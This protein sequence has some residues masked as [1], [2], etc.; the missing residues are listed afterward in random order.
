MYLAQVE[1]RLNVTLEHLLERARSW[2][3]AGR[4]VALAT[5]VVTWGS[6]PRPVGSHLAVDEAG[7]FVGSVSGGCIEGAVIHEA[8]AV[9]NDGTPRLLDFGVTNEQAWEVGLACGG[10]VQ[11]YIERVENVRMLELLLAAQAQ[12][13]PVATLT[14]LSDGAHALLRADETIGALTLGLEEREEAL[15]RLAA[16]KSGTLQTDAD[17]FLRVYAP[18]QRLLIVGAVHIAQ[19]LAPMAALTGF[20]V[21][22]IDPRRAFAA[23]ER[24]PDVTLCTDWP[25]EALARYQP[26]PGTAVVALSHDPKLDD[27]ALIAALDS[28]AFYIGALGSKRTHELRLKRLSREGCTTATLTRIHAPVGLDLGGRMPAEIA[29]SILAE[30]L[31]IRHKGAA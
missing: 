8:L 16:E 3:A 10:R 18:M 7:A 17:I 27:P 30:V 13:Q 22:V 31:Q 9:I 21:I 25:D 5:V 15:A 6:S 28:P 26:D 4:G 11:V 14:R 2:R 23:A 20:A 24:F 19:A 29:V 12:R 1:D